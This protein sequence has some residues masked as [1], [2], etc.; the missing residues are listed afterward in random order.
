MLF[1]VTL[2]I[3]KF[4]SRKSDLHANI[5]DED[6][7][8]VFVVVVFVC[9]LSLIH[10]PDFCK[11]SIFL[12]ISVA[13]QVVNPEERFLKSLPIYGHAHITGLNP[14][15]ICKNTPRKRTQM[16]NVYSMFL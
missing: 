12:L 10:K 14:I 5:I 3:A 8:P 6:Q 2:I 4:L 1:L 13:E 15:Y 7:Q 9:F 16:E 11:L